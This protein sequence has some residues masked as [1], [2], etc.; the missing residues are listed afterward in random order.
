MLSY[1]TPGHLGGGQRPT[2]PTS[3]TAGIPAAVTSRTQPASAPT[4]NIDS[5][6]INGDLNTK[7]HHIW[8][9]TGPAGCGKTTVAEHLATSLKLPY[10]EGDNVCSSLDII[11][12][13]NEKKVD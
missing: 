7:F 3:L 11:P 12:S 13:P 5:R 2:S 10:V 9:V 4:S 8:L 1:D 6:D